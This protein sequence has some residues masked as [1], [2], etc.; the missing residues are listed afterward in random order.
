MDLCCLPLVNIG[1]KIMQWVLTSFLYETALFCQK[2]YAHIIP[3][4]IAKAG[5]N[6]NVQRNKSLN[7]KPQY[8]SRYRSCLLNLPLSECF[9]FSCMYQKTLTPVRQRSLHTLTKFSC[10]QWKKSIPADCPRPHDGSMVKQ[11][12]HSISSKVPGMKC[13][14]AALDVRLSGF[15][16]N[17]SFSSIRTMMA[18]KSRPRWWQ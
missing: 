18:F 16:L 4:S 14:T 17:H 13:V 12:S 11:R 8:T 5:N 2:H 1:E 10:G 15:P 9:K 6:V 3:L 7:V